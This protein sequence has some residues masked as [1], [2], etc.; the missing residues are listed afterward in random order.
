MYP[1]SAQIIRS[2]LSPSG[3]AR[4]EGPRAGSMSDIG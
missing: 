1:H 3:T 2:R 4:T